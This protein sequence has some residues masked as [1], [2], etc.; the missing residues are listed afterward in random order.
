MRKREGKREGV[1][2]L[3]RELE[4]NKPRDSEA[5]RIQACT[6][7]PTVTEREAIKNVR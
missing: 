6:L 2:M 7:R 4:V 5:N 1:G 3:G